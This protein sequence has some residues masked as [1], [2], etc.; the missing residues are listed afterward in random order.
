MYV[1]MLKISYVLTLLSTAMFLFLLC[2]LC[3]FRFT[4]P[5]PDGK[6]REPIPLVVCTG[7]MRVFPVLA[8]EGS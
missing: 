1:Y 8:I 3:T 4:D 5:D 2:L 7:A 6:G